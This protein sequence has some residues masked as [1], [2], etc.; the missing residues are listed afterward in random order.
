VTTTFE[1]YDIGADIDITPP[2]P[3]DVIDPGESLG[4]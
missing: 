1:V 4:E 3:S 2:D